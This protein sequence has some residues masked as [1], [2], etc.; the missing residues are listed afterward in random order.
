MTYS[1]NELPF[2]HAIANAVLGNAAFRAYL[3]EETPFAGASYTPVPADVQ[4]KL[5]SKNMKNP[6]WFN[7]FRNKPTCPCCSGKGAETDVLIVSESADAKRLALHF[8]IKTPIGKLEENQ[9][10]KYPRRAECWAS[11]ATRPNFI[12][13][14]DAALTFLIGG[15]VLQSDPRI[16]HFDRTI[17]YDEIEQYAPTAS[18]TPSGNP[19]HR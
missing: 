6:Y 15:R 18:L 13:P 16:A 12:P 8:E 17:Y 4:A 11:P 5:R 10:E 1:K 9:A 7:Y 2:A 14:H 3:L 19:S